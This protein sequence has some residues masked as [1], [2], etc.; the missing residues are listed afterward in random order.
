MDQSKK[1][2]EK[3]FLFRTK[4]KVEFVKAVLSDFFD[5]KCIFKYEKLSKVI[6]TSYQ[7]VIF[8]YFSH[9]PTN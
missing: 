6:I 7:M 5:R 8:A 4:V 3:I 1:L 9:F 2:Q